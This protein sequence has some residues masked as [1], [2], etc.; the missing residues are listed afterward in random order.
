MADDVTPLG[1]RAILLRRPPGVSA[2]ALVACARAWPG[3]IDVVVTRDEV[4]VYFDGI[5]H[6]GALTGEVVEP[7]PRVVELRAVY[8]GPDLED[9]A[10]AIDVTPADVVALHLAPTYTVETMGFAPGFAYL[11]GLDAR[12]AGIPRRATPRPRVGAG[13]LA[14]AGGYTAVYPFDSPGGW[15]LIGHVD[16]RMFTARGARLALG[17][18][19]RFVR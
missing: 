6:A 12:L 10:R 7:A 15:N 5:P 4:A 19:V 14:I 13:A 1:D 2:R 9:V 3:A 11:V 18:Q 8:D 17:D 16:E